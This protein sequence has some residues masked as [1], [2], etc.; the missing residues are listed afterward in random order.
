M[1]DDFVVSNSYGPDVLR[2]LVFRKH[3]TQLDVHLI[4]LLAFY[5]QLIRWGF[6]HSSSSRI[7]SSPVNFWFAAQCFEPG[8]DG[9][10]NWSEISKFC[11]SWSGILQA[12]G[13]GS[14]F[15]SF[16]TLHFQYSEIPNNV[17]RS[18]CKRF[19]SCYLGHSGF[20]TLNWIILIKTIQ[21]MVPGLKK[22]NKERKF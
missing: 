22:M 9:T 6:V 2:V 17:T 8:I 10:P 3:V 12:L 1:T 4:L 21:F 13:R 11:W 16:Q 7:L 5:I 14:L 20:S 15:W 19:S 18:L